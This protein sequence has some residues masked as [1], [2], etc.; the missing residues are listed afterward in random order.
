MPL[1][2]ASEPVIVVMLA[3]RDEAVRMACAKIN[4]AIENRAF[5][6]KGEA[7]NKP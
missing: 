1:A 6:Q 5:L 3:P 4:Q 7:Q 2:A